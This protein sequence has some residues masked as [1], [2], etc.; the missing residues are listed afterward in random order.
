MRLSRLSNRQ[1]RRLL[2]RAEVR[3]GKGFGYELQDAIRDYI[4]GLFYI[5]NKGPYKAK[6]DKKIIELKGKDPEL[7]EKLKRF[8]RL[9]E[10]VMRNFLWDRFNKNFEMKKITRID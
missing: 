10:D 6:L 8:F 3:F 1:L 2:R 4:N 9:H 7:A 5:A